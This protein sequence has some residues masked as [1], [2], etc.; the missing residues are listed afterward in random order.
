MD[1]QHWVDASQRSLEARTTNLSTDLQT[2]VCGSIST[3]PVYQG[4]YDAT[5][6]SGGPRE[7]CCIL[8]DVSRRINITLLREQLLSLSTL[9]LSAAIVLEIMYGYEVQPKNDQIIQ[10][11]E[12]AIQRLIENGAN[13]SVA[14]LN[15]FPV[16]RHLPR[17]FPGT[18]FH[19]I[20]DECRE[21]TKDMLNVP[22]EYVLRSM[23]SDDGL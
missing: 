11:T 23:V 1:V 19:Q 21:F 15:A 9:R 3:H 7:L 10:V 4:P 16:L 13:P 18:G 17:W 14:A 2:R 20:V 6:A 5:T 8:Q 12:R 22:F